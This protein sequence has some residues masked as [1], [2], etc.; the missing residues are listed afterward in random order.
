MK[1]LIVDDSLVMQDA[2]E[3]YLDDR[4]SGTGDHGVQAARSRDR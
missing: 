1:L 3:K 2:I 4:R